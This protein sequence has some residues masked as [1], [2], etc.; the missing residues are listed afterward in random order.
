MNERTNEQQTRRMIATWQEIG[1]NVAKDGT[2]TDRAAFLDYLRDR[3]SGYSAIMYDRNAPESVR[4]AARVQWRAAVA[5]W[6]CFLFCGG[7]RI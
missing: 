2:A 1:E 5:A 7:D 6:R 4:D 3:I